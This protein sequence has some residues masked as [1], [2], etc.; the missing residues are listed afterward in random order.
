MRFKSLLKDFEKALHYLEFMNKKVYKSYSN[1][2]NKESEL[3]NNLTLE[4]FISNG[5]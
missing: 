4:T 3:M 1:F 5:W 2:K